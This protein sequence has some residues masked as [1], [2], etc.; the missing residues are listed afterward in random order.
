VDYLE[1]KFRFTRETLARRHTIEDVAMFATTTLLSVIPTHKVALA[2]IEGN[3][4]KLV[5]TT[6][7]RAILDLNLNQ[8]SI[9]ARTIKTRRTQ[10]VND[11]SRDPDYFPGDPNETMSSELCV[12]MVHMGRV[13]GTLTFEHQQPGRYKEEDARLAETFAMEIAEAIYRV[14]EPKPSAEGPQAVVKVKARSTVEIYRD[15]LKA[16]HEGETVLNRIINRAMMRWADGKE[17]V[18][19]LVVKG[20][21]SSGSRL[22]PADTCT[23]SLRKAPRL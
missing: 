23:G 19:E 21:P 18:N 5:S 12:P 11:T 3:T 20:Y 13:L 16:V 14:Q 17:V 4:L 6:G 15:L 9:N 22:R 7:K 2:V 1:D 10:L 8:P